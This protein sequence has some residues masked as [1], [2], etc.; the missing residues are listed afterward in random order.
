MFGAF[1][2]LGERRVVVCLNCLEISESK[3]IYGIVVQY[4]LKLN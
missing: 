2:G 4:S 1:D 3:K